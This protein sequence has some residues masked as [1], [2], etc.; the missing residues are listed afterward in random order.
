[1]IPVIR[2]LPH[3]FEFADTRTILGIPN[4]WNVVSNLPFLL[5]AMWGLRAFRSKTAFTEGWE[6]AAY[7]TVLAGGA[8]TALGSAYFH[9][10]PTPAT[11]FWDRLPMTLVFMGVLAGVLGRSWMLWPLVAAGVASVLWWRWSGNLLGYVVVQYGGSLAVVLLLFR[12]ARYTGTGWLWAMLALYGAAKAL[13]LGDRV[14]A[15]GHAW[16]HAAAAGA[17]ACYCAHVARRTPCRSI[18]NTSPPSV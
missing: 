2:D 9:W 8:L 3:Y 11:L 18:D 14:V 13:E 15:G 7:A 12:R 4:F 1:M 6:R 16:K 5:V 10:N 17:L